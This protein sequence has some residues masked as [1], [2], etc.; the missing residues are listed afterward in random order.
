M[1]NEKSDDAEALLTE[2]YDSMS[3]Y[4]EIAAHNAAKRLYICLNVIFRMGLPMDE[5]SS[6]DEAL[7]KDTKQIY[8]A[9]VSL[10]SC[11]SD[12]E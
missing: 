5:K 8:D 3:K 2:F 6:F 10:M 4:T 1:S 11:M 12:E 9:I 7:H